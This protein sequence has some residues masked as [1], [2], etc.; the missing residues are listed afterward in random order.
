MAR[1]SM[2]ARHVSSSRR[3]WLAFSLTGRDLR[4][5]PGQREV[6]FSHTIVSLDLRGLCIERKTIG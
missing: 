4:D 2:R 3:R 1:K 6:A 5:W